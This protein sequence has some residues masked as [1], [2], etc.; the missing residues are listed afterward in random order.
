MRRE[1]IP[2]LWTDLSVAT[3]DATSPS[4]QSPTRQTPTGTWTEEEHDRFLQAMKLYPAGPWKAIAAYV[5][6]RSVRQVHTH[7]QKYHE[8]LQRRQRGLRKT[9]KGTKTRFSGA[10]HRVELTTDGKIRKEMDLQTTSSERGD[11]ANNSRAAS[12]LG[13]PIDR[14][15]LA[16]RI[17]L[18]RIDSIAI[19]G[20]PTCLSTSDEGEMKTQQVD[21]A[22]SH[23]GL[24]ESDSMLPSFT[25]SLDFL[26][27]YYLVECGED[28]SEENT[29][30]SV[31]V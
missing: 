19:N 13:S 26:L 11:S 25:E 8:K 28:A 23:E 4:N 22:E 12:P 31:I 1:S 29:Q 30:P 3:F 15:F 17:S 2:S 20:F 18:P 5:G 10:G 7:A 21:G 16:D 9:R 14:Q 27:R 6:T 24:R